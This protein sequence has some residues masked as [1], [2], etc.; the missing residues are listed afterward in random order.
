MAPCASSVSGLHLPALMKSVKGSCTV[1]L[2]EGF[3]GRFGRSLPMPEPEIPPCAWWSCL[4]LC[5]RPC[6]PQPAKLPQL[7]YKQQ[8]RTFDVA[9]MNDYDTFFDSIVTRRIKQV[10][11][12]CCFICRLSA[13]R[14][15]ARQ[16]RTFNIA[17]LDFTLMLKQWTGGG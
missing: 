9:D 11:Y 13:I 7:G 12:K 15:L 3:G 14:A 5:S 17:W 8:L 6:C 4:C 10:K 16:N 2:A 1:L